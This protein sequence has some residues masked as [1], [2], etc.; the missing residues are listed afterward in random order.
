MKSRGM[1]ADSPCRCSRHRRYIITPTPNAVVLIPRSVELMPWKFKSL[2]LFAIPC[3][4]QL[5][6]R[7]A[8]LS[9]FPFIS[10]PNALGE[11]DMAQ[12]K[13]HRRIVTLLH[14]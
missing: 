8:A 4:A 2:G 1:L 13:T 11:L 7:E 10:P 12:C 14:P 9:P 3:G 5:H 6:D